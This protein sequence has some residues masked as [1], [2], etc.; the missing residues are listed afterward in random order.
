[1]DSNMDYVRRFLLRKLLSRHLKQGRALQLG[2]SL[3]GPRWRSCLRDAV[4]LEERREFRRHALDPAQETHRILCFVELQSSPV[5][6]SGKAEQVALLPQE[7]G[8]SRS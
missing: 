6:L 5:S 8:P 1:M 2:V 7:G 3:D 4:R